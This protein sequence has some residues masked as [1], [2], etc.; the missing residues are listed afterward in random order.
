MASNPYVKSLFWLISI[1]G[2]GYGLMR[3]TAPSEEKIAKIRATTAGI[4]L[5]EDEKKKVLF[6]KKLQEA[7]YQKDPVYLKKPEN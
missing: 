3:L 2:L 7:A 5:T 1:G 6:L 4:H